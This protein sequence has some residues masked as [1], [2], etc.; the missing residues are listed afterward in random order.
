MLKLTITINDEEKVFEL[1]YDK[2]LKVS[3]EMIDECLMNQASSY[4]FYAVLA[5]YADDE[6]RRAKHDLELLEAHLDK[7]VR[8]AATEKMTETRIRSEIILTKDWQTLA[9]HI[10]D[11]KFNSGAL[12]GIKRSFEHRKD[13]VV[14][15]GYKRGKEM[16][17]D[18]YIKK[19]QH[20]AE[21]DNQ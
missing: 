10:L 18:I 13:S 12:A 14:A 7:A 9:R 15:L 20:K 17:S 4:S 16:D 8:S 11:L 19:D 1:D 6:L 5:E 3:G 21:I 2:H